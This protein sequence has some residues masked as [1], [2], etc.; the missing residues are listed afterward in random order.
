MVRVSGRE[1]KSK[2]KAEKEF[3]LSSPLLLS[4]PHFSSDFFFSYPLVLLFVF[5]LVLAVP[6]FC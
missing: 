6:S 5:V 1:T 2:T 4:P 3:P